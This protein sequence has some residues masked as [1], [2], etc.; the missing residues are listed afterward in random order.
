[1]DEVVISVTKT[2]ELFGSSQMVFE[3]AQ[4]PPNIFLVPYAGE[5]VEIEYPDIIRTESDITLEYNRICV[6]RIYCRPDNENPHSGNGSLE[7]PFANFG[8]AVS[9]FKCMS[10]RVCADMF[11]IIL[12][13]GDSMIDLS[14]V[15]DSSNLI[16]GDLAAIE[17]QVVL[18]NHYIYLR[19]SI[20]AGLLINGTG[21]ICC[22]SMINCTC[23][24]GS[25]EPIENVINSDIS[26]LQFMAHTIYGSRIDMSSDE[27]SDAVKLVCEYLSS[28]TL[29]IN[30]SY[31][32]CW[33]KESLCSSK[34]SICYTKGLQYASDKPQIV[35]GRVEK[36]E[37]TL[38]DIFLSVNSELF[39]SVISFFGITHN[40]NVA[41]ITA[42]R[43]TS[44]TPIINNVSISAEFSWNIL[45]SMDSPEDIGYRNTVVA[46]HVPDISQAA[47]FNLSTSVSCSVDYFN[48]LSA[49]A[50]CGIAD[51]VSGCI[52][53]C[54]IR[55]GSKHEGFNCGAVYDFQ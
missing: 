46:L 18:N 35:I 7:N 43:C 32:T 28:S 2:G 42:V 54:D 52:H 34:A 15:P 39:N 16:I 22:R 47:I 48:E 30:A 45:D 3:S 23:N 11:Q 41:H 50:K 21:G 38:K 13:P 20:L 25:F 53:D 1:M 31:I 4:F 17:R 10:I 49:V 36:S 26:A 12:L 37:L 14:E 44:K 55:L 5:S 9:W 40:Y 51:G 19:G 27:P 29:N 6:R 33:V 8:D 24:T